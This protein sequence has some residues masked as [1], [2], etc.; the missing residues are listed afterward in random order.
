M[1]ISQ[2][3]SLNTMRRLM[4]QLVNWH[5]VWK[6]YMKGEVPPTLRFRSG[7]RMRHRIED[8]PVLMV[9]EVFADGNYRKGVPVK[10]PMVI[11][12]IGANIGAVCLDWTYRVPDL[13]IHAYEPNPETVQLLHENLIMNS[14]DERV[15]VFCE[16]VG[17]ECGAMRLWTNVP[18]VLASCYGDKPPIEG[19]TKIDVPSVNLDECL[20]R[21]GGES[22]NLL[23]ID[24]EGAEV[25]ILEGAQQST[26]EAIRHIVLEYHDDIVAESS[27]SCLNILQRSGFRCR[28]QKEK[29]HTGLIYAWR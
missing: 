28:I 25:D 12:D 1:A 18:S 15:A 20:R 8:A 19:G 6:C 2:I 27:R 21:L 16:A 11:L 23:K 5:P 7:I 22:V 13:T 9:F 14:V 10:K 3:R 24:A 4:F 26:L 17:R 29:A